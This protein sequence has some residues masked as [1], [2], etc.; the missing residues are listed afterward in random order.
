ML[1]LRQMQVRKPLVAARVVCGKRHQ[2]APRNKNKVDPVSCTCIEVFCVELPSLSSLDLVRTHTSQHMHSTSY[3][4]LKCM[5]RGFSIATRIEALIFLIFLGIDRCMSC[6]VGGRINM[7]LTSMCE[8][9]RHCSVAAQYN[10]LQDTGSRIDIEICL[11]V[12]R[13]L[14]TRFLIVPRID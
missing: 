12:P 4:G 9:S 6:R 14:L 8:S 11:H 1:E 7:Q 10:R 3:S 2:S 13:V 5:I